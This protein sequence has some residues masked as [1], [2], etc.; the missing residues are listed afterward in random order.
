MKDPA[1][2]EK[3]KK[4]GERIHND[5]VEVREN[6]AA[7]LEGSKSGTCYPPPPPKKKDIAHVQ[8]ITQFF[9]QY[10]FFTV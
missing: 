10:L 9:E 2:L 4:L 8:S 7:L 3:F 1:N 5:L 6:L